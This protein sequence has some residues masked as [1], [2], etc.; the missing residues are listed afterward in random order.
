[1]LE[2]LLYLEKWKE[3]QFCEHLMEERFDSESDV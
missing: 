3:Y 1:M 2:G